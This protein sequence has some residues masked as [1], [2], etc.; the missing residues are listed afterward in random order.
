MA[1]PKVRPAG[2]A[3]LLSTL[4]LLACGGGASGGGGTT[5]AAAAGPPRPGGAVDLAL[6]VPANASTVLNANLSTVRQDP[7]RYDRIAS[8]LASELQLTT[9][10]ST[11]RSLL[12]RTD[13]AIGV[14]MPSSAPPAQE[15]MLIFA[16]NYADTDF[17]QAI[18]MAASRHGSTPAPSSGADGRMVYAFGNAT[19]V[20]F[21][22]WTWA[23]SVGPQARAHLSQ[24][25]LAG[26]RAFSTNLLE[27][28][29]RIGLPSGAAQAWADQDQQVG[30]DMV[31]LVFA[32]EHP[33]MVHDFVATVS[34]HLGI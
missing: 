18:A 11:L 20:K 29:P 2:I 13:R 30:V 16:G 31:A 12:D 10:A 7:A 33:S 24:V 1:E 5:V 28:G 32:G 3:A 27:F 4:L 6:M 34:R 9:E 21:D 19:L 17:D 22:Q 25:S 8:Q 26:P 23:V 14:F 15:G